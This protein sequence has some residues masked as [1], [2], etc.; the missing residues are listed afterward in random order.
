MSNIFK[1]SVLTY[2]HS[3]LL[4]EKINVGIIFYFPNAGGER[5]YFK[6]PKKLHRLKTFYT[7][8]SEW[9]LK[10]YLVSIEAKT[11]KLN[12]RFSSKGLNLYSDDDLVDI[13][14]HEY[15]D[16]ATTLQFS[17]IKKGKLYSDID[18]VITQFYNL[19][20]SIYDAGSETHDPY[21]D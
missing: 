8:F 9:Q 15:K 18:S 17:E 12:A 13:I 21:K 1:Y 10:N 7:D 16:D 19:Y 11:H 20:F 4:N 2:N 14:H 6:Y 3:Q 5:L